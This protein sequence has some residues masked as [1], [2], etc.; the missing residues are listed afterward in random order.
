MNRG[1]RIGRLFGITI[2][3]DWSWLVIFAL[4]TWSLG[5]GL[6]QLHGSWPTATVWFVAIVAALLFFGSVLAH[7]LAHSLFARSRGIPVKSI[8]LFL[9]GGVSSIEKEPD[10]PRSEFFMAILGPL[11]SFVIGVVLLTITRLLAGPMAGNFSDPTLAARGMGPVTTVLL[12]LGSIN[13]ILAVFNM[14]PGFPLD[15]GRVLRSIV[16]AITGDLKRATRVASWAGQGV[17][18][19]LI[20]SG[21]SMIFGA[22]L[23]YFGTGAGGLWLAFIG[24]FLH[25][26]A[27]QSYRQVVVQDILRDVP[28]S[29]MAIPNPPTVAPDST[30]SALVHDHIMR[31]DDHAFPVVEGDRLIGLVTL[32][33]VRSVGR[34]AW[35]TSRVRE[36]MTSADRLITVTPDEEASDALNKLVRKDVR[37]LPVVEGGRLVGLVRRRDIVRWLQLHSEGG[38]GVSR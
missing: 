22:R 32:G 11:T 31:S 28:V 29:E 35:D 6:G 19:L 30:V 17:G 12:W 8:T 24:W 21:I 18:L 15:G 23:P 16:W 7:E 27:T 38:L 10:S 26:A 33:D 25:S 2:N 1:F 34:D 13:I 36:I 4:V 5:S 37:Q 3:A 14:I 9:F 20:V